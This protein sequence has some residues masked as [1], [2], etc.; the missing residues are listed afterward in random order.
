MFI[1]FLLQSCFSYKEID[2]NPS[3]LTIGHHYKMHSS[4]KKIKG[5][6]KSNDGNVIVLE[7]F[8]EQKE[9]P[10]SAIKTIEK[11]QYS[12]VKTVVLL[13]FTVGIGGFLIQ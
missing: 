8:G 5:M 1:L 13:V 6:L 3:K 4:D 9:M 11:R 2:S 10:V 7:S 12:V